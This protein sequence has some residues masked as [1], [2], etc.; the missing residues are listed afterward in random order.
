VPPIAYKLRSLTDLPGL[1][2]Q[3]AGTPTHGVLVSVSVSAVVY[4]RILV[5]DRIGACPYCPYSIRKHPENGTTTN[6]S[7]TATSEALDSYPGSSETRSFAYR[8]ALQLVHLSWRT[9][10][11]WQQLPAHTTTACRALAS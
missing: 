7:T 5:S 3:V 10:V 2:L 1:I 11:R 8:A 9:A 6:L 4:T